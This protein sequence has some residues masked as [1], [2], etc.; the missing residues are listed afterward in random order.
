MLDFNSLFLF[1]SLRLAL[2]E[3]F[4]ALLI[5]NVRVQRIGREAA[6]ILMRVDQGMFCPILLVHHSIETFVFAIDCRRCHL[7]RL[8]EVV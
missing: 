7:V 8:I 5:I 2:D 4:G 3:P 1:L 6:D